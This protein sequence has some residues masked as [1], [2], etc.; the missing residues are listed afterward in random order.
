MHD[1]S[2]AHH[3][4]ATMASLASTALGLERLDKGEAVIRLFVV[5]GALVAVLLPIRSTGSE[6]DSWLL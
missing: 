2:R 4:R 3:T 6:E 5:L 1:T